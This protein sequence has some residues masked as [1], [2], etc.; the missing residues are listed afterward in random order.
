MIDLTFR[1]GRLNVVVAQQ[2]TARP[3]TSTR[4]GDSQ[5]DS[6]M[7][8]IYVGAQHYRDNATE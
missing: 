8:T 6:R 1:D 3:A 2:I 4:A 5:V 7:A